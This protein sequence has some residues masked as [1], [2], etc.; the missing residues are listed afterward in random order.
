MPGDAELAAGLIAED[1]VLLVFTP[2]APPAA[3]TA[4]GL[5]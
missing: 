5:G 2:S 3:W 4:V 1:R